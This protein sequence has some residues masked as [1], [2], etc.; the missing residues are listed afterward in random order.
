MKTILI[1]S[2]LILL[3][4]CSTVCKM[5]ANK[6]PNIVV[7][8]EYVIRK[9][10]E[11]MFDIPPYSA[12]LNI[13]GFTQKDIATWITESEGRTQILENKIQALKKFQDSPIT[14]VEIP[15]K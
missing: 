1:L 5:C 7:K 3:S 4:G 14:P 2:I 9:A 15:T 8:T 6:N 11:T 12:R 13:D 10:P